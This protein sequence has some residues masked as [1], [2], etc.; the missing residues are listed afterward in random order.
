M[1]GQILG[2]RYELIEKSAGEEWP[3][4]IKQGVNC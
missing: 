3:M 1:V 2:N 4:Y